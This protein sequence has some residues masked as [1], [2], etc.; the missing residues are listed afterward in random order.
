MTERTA[1]VIG[2]G[3]GGLALAIRLQ[4]SGIRTTLLEARDKPGGRAYVYE[5]EGFTFDAGPTVITDPNCLRQLWGLSGREL[6][7]Y[8][9]LLPVSPFYQ[10][11][12][13]DGDRF[14]YLDDQAALDR[15]IAARSPRDVDGYRR[16]RAYSE[17]VYREGYE[18][19]GTVPF[20]NFWSMA[21]VAPALAALRADRSVYATVARYIED[22][23]LRQVFSFHPLL[24]GGNP[25]RTSA[26]YALIHALERRGA[27]GSRRGARARS[28]ARWRAFSR[29]WGANS[30]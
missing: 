29:I 7:D 2:A 28:S 11:R 13:E 17:A 26:I 3:F 1:A 10:L 6:A 22:E 4:S 30:C 15:Q 20:L 24:V 21:R 9:T 19:L 5:D 23:R 18:K 27:S 16:F 25:F 14:D 8:T 12:W